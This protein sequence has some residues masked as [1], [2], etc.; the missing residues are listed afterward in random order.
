M[1][2]SRRGPDLLQRRSTLDHRRRLRYQF[3]SLLGNLKEVEEEYK[4]L[5]KDEKQSRNER[6][7]EYEDLTLKHVD[8][9]NLYARLYGTTKRYKEAKASLVAPAFFPHMIGYYENIERESGVSGWGEIKGGEV[10]A[11]RENRP[12]DWMNLLMETVKGASDKWFD[13]QNAK[14]SNEDWKGGNPPGVY[15]SHQPPKVHKLVCSL[16]TLM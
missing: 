16:L 3:E 15:C 9:L 13:L 12:P 2:N 8:V 4:Q 7:K 14:T 10:K 1:T 11:A 6:V 5:Y